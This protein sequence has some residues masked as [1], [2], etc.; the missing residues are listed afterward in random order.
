[1]ISDLKQDINFDRTPVS[2]NFGHQISSRYETNINQ[3]PH[4]NFIIIKGVCDGKLQPLRLPLCHPT[5][6]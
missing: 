4:R 6:L 5:D 3:I 1:M 2:T